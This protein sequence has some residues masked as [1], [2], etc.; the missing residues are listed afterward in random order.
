MK[1][2]F[3]KSSKYALEFRKM[4]SGFLRWFLKKN[5]FQCYNRSILIHHMSTTNYDDKNPKCFSLVV[6]ETKSGFFD[7]GLVIGYI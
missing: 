4:Y 7:S 5:N 3:G 6:C 1:N 2:N